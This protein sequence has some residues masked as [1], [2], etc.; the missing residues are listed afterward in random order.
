VKLRIER[1]N[2]LRRFNGR[3]VRVWHGTTETGEPCEILVA[4]MIGPGTEEARERFEGEL[5]DEGVPHEPL[6]RRHKEHQRQQAQ[7]AR[8][9]AH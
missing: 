1:T 7:A 9:D 6:C 2:R 8:K 3:D 4:A 5:A